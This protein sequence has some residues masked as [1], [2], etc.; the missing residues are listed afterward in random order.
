MTGKIEIAVK[1]D[2]GRERTENQDHF[3]V[4]HS[5]D[6]AV[7]EK[8]GSLVVVA[9][10][11]GGHSGGK[12]A[13]E[14][15]VGAI[16]K[17]FDAT[18]RRSMRDILEEAVFAANDAVRQMQQADVRIHDAGTTCVALLVRGNLAVVAHLG[19]SRCYL[20][21]GDTIHRITR[22]HTY[23][24]ELID[25]GLITPEQAQGH[26][27]RNIITR[28]V[29][30]STKLEVDFNRCELQKGDIFLMC[31]DGLSNPVTD[32]EMAAAVRQLS[33]E[34][35]AEKLIKLAND[36]GGDDNITVAIVKVE[37]PG[38]AIPEL[39]KLDADQ[40]LFSAKV[41]PVIK[42]EDLGP[43]VVGDSDSDADTAENI[44][45]TRQERTKESRI[46]GPV[47]TAQ[48]LMSVM[49]KDGLTPTAGQAILAEAA[50][51]GSAHKIWYWII[52]AEIVVLVVLHFL[53]SRNY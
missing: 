49:E 12:L 22:D 19:D 28:C 47:T 11:M 34:K 9:D 42:R 17:A 52:A 50:P 3:G 46:K 21:R 13:S 41:T 4:L 27:D 25:I 20:F 51:S 8:K 37:E 40:S 5:S 53:I 2:V 1:S 31:S 18:Q 15:A 36:R 10:G 14:T 44:V 24:N 6:P 29:G 33:P 35:A 26:P 43:G 48:P 23:L 7:L 32:Q 38:T 30:M 39:A 16:L 45:S